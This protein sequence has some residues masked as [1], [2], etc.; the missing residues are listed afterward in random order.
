MISCQDCELVCKDQDDLK[1]HRTESCPHLNKPSSKAD[2]ESNTEL[3]EHETIKQAS[4]TD[5]ENP[6][7]EIDR[8]SE[9]TKVLARF[10]VDAPKVEIRDCIRQYS[11][12]KSYKQQTISFNAYNKNVIVEPKEVSFTWPQPKEQ[13]NALD[14]F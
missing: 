5:K 13:I 2:A 4:T 7:E 3:A 11:E 6:Q 1:T 9:T 12:S 14:D 10:C 8:C